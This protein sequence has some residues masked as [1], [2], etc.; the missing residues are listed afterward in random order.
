MQIQN[1]FKIISYKLSTS[2]LFNNM[3]EKSKILHIKKIYKIL[4]LKT[5][6]LHNVTVE[7]Y[8]LFT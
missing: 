1:T 5:N 6:I 3:V 8:T 7:I 4:R 2:I